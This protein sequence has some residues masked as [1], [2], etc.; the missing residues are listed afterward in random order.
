MQSKCPAAA[1]TQCSPTC[2]RPGPGCRVLQ[3]FDEYQDRRIDLSERRLSQT[4]HCVQPIVLR[5]PET[6]RRALY[7][8]RLMSH[9]IEGMPEAQSEALLEE[10]YT[11]AEDPEIRYQHVWTP[12]DLLMWDNLCS[13]HARTDFPPGERR[14]MRRFTLAGEPVIPAWETSPAA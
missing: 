5:H 7:V 4:P 2:T 1:A 13:T 3:A 6:G 8:N 12:G 11:Y 14:L 9:R 10:L